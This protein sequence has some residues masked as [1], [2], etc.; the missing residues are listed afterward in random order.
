MCFLGFIPYNKTLIACRFR[1]YENVFTHEYHI[2]LG[3]C[4]QGIWYSWVNTCSYFPHQHAINVYYCNHIHQIT[5]VLPNHTF[6]EEFEHNLSLVFWDYLSN[7]LWLV[8]VSWTSTQC[9]MRHGDFKMKNN[10]KSV[11]PLLFLSCI[12][13]DTRSQSDECYNSHDQFQPIG[14]LYKR[15]HG[16]N[17]NSKN[18]AG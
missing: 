2:P 4:S 15:S 9:Q 6:H 16:V 3:R 1:K 7:K 13:W 17:A 12:D 14:K 8:F 18:I 10:N 5:V 11:V